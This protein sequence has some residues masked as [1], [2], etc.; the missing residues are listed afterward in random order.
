M[1]Y[2]TT[3]ERKDAEKLESDYDKNHRNAR[4][5]LIG[6]VCA[7]SLM[8]LSTFLRLGRNCKLFVTN[9]LV[10]ASLAVYIVYY[11]FE[12]EKLKALEKQQNLATKTDGISMK[13]NQEKAKIQLELLAIQMFIMILFTYYVSVSSGTAKRDGDGCIGKSTRAGIFFPAFFVLG[14]AAYKLNKTWEDDKRKNQ[15]IR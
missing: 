2:T 8:I 5:A 14:Y 10:F 3:K 4:W 11:S 13:S 15:N 7:M 6:F 9:V 12:L 1:A